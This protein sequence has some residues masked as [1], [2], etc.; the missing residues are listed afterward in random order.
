MTIRTEARNTP[1]SISPLPIE[2]LGLSVRSYNALKA[3]GVKTVGELLRLSD[4]QLL[5]FYAV[6]R[7]SLT[8][9]RRALAKYLESARSGQVATHAPRREQSRSEPAP[10]SAG[11]YSQ[12]LSRGGWVTPPGPP[13]PLDLPVGVLDLPTRAANVLS[14]LRVDSIRQLLNHPKQELVK[15]ENFGRTSLAEIQTKLFAYL[16][17]GQPAEHE[18]RANAGSVQHSTP[19]AIPG[20]KAF[21]EEILAGLPER[22][23][24]VIADRYG[25]WDGIAETLQDIGDKLGVTRERI[26][27]VEEKGLARLR[28]V[29]GHRTV[30]EFVRR[31]MRTY[32]E[33]RTESKGGVITEDEA[34]EVLA[35]DCKVEEAALAVLLLQDICCPG[36]VIF[37]HALTEAEPGV[38]CFDRAI[39]AAY[40]K[41]LSIVEAV[42]RHHQKP[43]PGAKLYSKLATSVGT[44][45][46]PPDEALIGRMLSVSP[47]VVELKDGT[48]A[49]SS[50]TEFRRRDARSVAEAA[51]RL[52]GRPAHFREIA[53]KA[54]ELRGDAA[55]VN[56]RT[57][58]N[59]LIR[60]PDKFVWVRSGTYGLAAWGLRKPP[61]IKDR[62][63]ELLSETR[64]PLPFWHLK[65]KALE[66]C[67]CKEE[68]VRMTLDLNPR[69]FR[70]FEGDQYGLRKHFDG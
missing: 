50:W 48:V 16:A 70:K 44:G 26:R 47:A 23:R 15:A 9:T 8:D 49:L 25:L 40:T 61:F 55:E 37:G 52:L 67:N 66:V 14:R 4:Q 65:E 30:V 10:A 64:Y 38:Y 57:I 46:E 60:S 43:I 35:R 24:T 32:L 28:R 39:A 18:P 17:Q 36:K 7:K 1:E 21:V 56:G 68:S 27:Q 58:H 69:L 59:A 63:V 33:P 29:H 20:A 34:V 12:G 42:L 54:G 5:R 53:E 31:S 11:E 2:E 22:E 13:P 6:G 41:L 45:L 3:N 19:A 62:L 51:L